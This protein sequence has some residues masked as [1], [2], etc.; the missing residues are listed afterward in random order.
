MDELNQATENKKKCF[1]NDDMYYIG[2]GAS[3]G[4]LE[5][6]EDFFKAMPNDSGMAFIVVQHLSPD[7]K[8]LMNELLARRTKMPVVIAENDMKVMPNTVYL[9]SPG[10]DLTLVKGK[11]VLNFHENPSRLNLPI[12]LFFRSLANDQGKKAIAVVLSGT[13]SDGTLGIRAIKEAGGM[14]MAQDD[15]TAKFDGMP[16]SSISTGLVDFILPPQEMGTEIMNYIKHPYMKA[17]KLV[18][19]FEADKQKS[20]TFTRILLLLSTYCGID[21][22]FYKENTIIR[23]LERRVSVNRLS[24]LED[25]YILL[26]ES[27]K[28]KDTLYKELLI[29]VTNFFRDKEAFTYFS[30]QIIPNFN[31]EK[32]QI[33]IWCSPCSTGEEAYSIAMLVKDYIETNQID[34]DIKIFATDIE[35][36][37]LDFAGRG[38]YSESVV[39][40]IDSY[41]LE[42]YFVCE[43]NTYQVKDCIRNIVVF[44]SHNILKDPPFSKLDLLVCRNLFIYLKPDMQQ[45]LLGMFYYSLNPKGY[46]FMGS[47]ESIGEM[48]EAYTVV[49]SKWKMY[50]VKSNYSSHMT[51]NVFS[52][53]EKVLLGENRLPLNGFTGSRLKIEKIVEAAAAVALPP[54]ILIDSDG[55]IIH[56]MNDVNPYLTI[57]P[58]RFS[59]SI[60]ANISGDLSLFVSSILRRLKNKSSSVICE[61]ITGLEHFENQRITVKAYTVNFHN[62][63]FY[64]FSFY[65]EEHNIEENIDFSID[66]K[67]IV[68]LRIAELEKELQVGKEN[69]Q[70]TVEELE[71]SNEELQSSNE[72]LIA[73]NEELQSTNEELQSVNEELYTV[74]SE[75]QSKIEEL[76]CITEDLDNLLINAEIGALYL[77]SK[78]CIRK[79]TPLMSKVTNIMQSDIGR[80]IYHISFI[81]SYPELVNDVKNVLENLQPIQKELTDNEDRSWSIRIRPY[82]TSSF[83]VDG[84]LLTLFDITDSKRLERSLEDMIL[85][86]DRQED[87]L[88]DKESLFQKIFE[89]TKTLKLFVNEDKKVLYLN[90]AAKYFFKNCNPGEILPSELKYSYEQAKTQ[91]K[92]AF[93]S[94]GYLTD[95]IGNSKNV[96]I[97]AEPSLSPKGRFLGILFIIRIE[98]N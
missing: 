96:S 15:H 35:R 49:N 51:S 79:I 81:D 57:K 4:G 41:Y 76:N 83:A 58:G 19:E 32:K 13:G 71:T 70:A 12:N 67:D 75:Y 69:L 18:D 80:P 87:S 28:E 88:E 52:M 95:A 31:Y 29:G 97:I 7:Y 6:L 78:L 47:S 74:N 3:A 63:L 36:E 24:T 45:K 56:V 61:H 94:M 1:D 40:D 33:R 72:E 68:S 17:H 64:L 25:Y 22:S 62:G 73:S 60:F 9:N 55:N 85:R 30:K 23:R 93:C 82:R 27:D 16:R 46:L 48:S 91:E 65:S 8:S 20:D 90:N 26:K 43:D 98:G 50:Q 92:M 89:Y 14:I 10:N 84:I 59:S 2:I 37:S 11:F 66:S 44:A 77:D 86:L 21:F 5:A 42:K 39:A 53:Q 38:V 34:C 54:S